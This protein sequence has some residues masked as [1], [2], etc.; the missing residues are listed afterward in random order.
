M[1]P[2]ERRLLPQP[3]RARPGPVVMTT[4][5]WG[6]YE[7]GLAM[8]EGGHLG[9]AIVQGTIIHFTT[10]GALDRRNGLLELFP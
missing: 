5:N 6:A 1:L 9:L 4:A 2:Q 7:N 3:L 8:N 10:R